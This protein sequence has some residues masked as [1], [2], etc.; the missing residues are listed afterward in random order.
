MP[1]FHKIKRENVVIW[2]PPTSSIDVQSFAAAT[3]SPEKILFP[4]QANM[5]EKSGW[6]DDYILGS[7]FGNLFILHLKF[8]SHP[9]DLF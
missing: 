4:N 6:P 2:V 9:K 7:Y 5:C 8:Y 1:L 3:L